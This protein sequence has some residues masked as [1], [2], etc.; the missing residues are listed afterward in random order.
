MVVKSGA[1]IPPDGLLIYMRSGRS[2]I[3]RDTKN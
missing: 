3:I 1:L 2:G